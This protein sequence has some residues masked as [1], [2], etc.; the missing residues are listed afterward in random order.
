MNEQTIFLIIW[1]VITVF[2]L[3][4]SYWKGKKALAIFPNINFVN[5]IYQDKYASGYST[6]SWRTRI[7]GTRNMLKIV[8]T[9]NELWLTCNIL[10]AGIGEYYDLLHKI[11]LENIKKVEKQEKKITL[12]FKTNSGIDKQVVLITKQP[13]IFLKALNK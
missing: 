11:S 7:G 4:T 1:T 3:I 6:K 13:E 9:D 12:D 5:V 10:L 2:I 8:V